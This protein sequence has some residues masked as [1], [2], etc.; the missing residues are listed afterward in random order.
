MRQND[1]WDVRVEFR[2]A[3]DRYFFLLMA[4]IATIVAVATVKP[5]GW[6]ALLVVSLQS[7][8]A[9]LAV[10]TSD[11]KSRTKRLVRV[12]VAVSFSIVLLASVFGTEQIGHYAYSA[13]MLVLVAVV[14]VA[15]ARRLLS[16]E[17]VTLQ[18]VV[19]A[20]CIYLLVGLFF[21]VVQTAYQRETGAFFASGPTESPSDFVYF[22]FVTLATVGY[23]DLVPGAAMAR[24]IAIL[25]ALVGQL[26]L[27]TVVALLVS[28]LSRRDQPPHGGGIGAAIADDLEEREPGD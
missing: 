4:I 11:S 16:H 26:Y 28:N 1:D 12:T 27:V 20:L 22:S 10:S 24:M 19:G 15:I 18:T 17:R 7:F 8:T 21:V 6:G 13:L 9:L 5:E 2:H 23:G 3:L 14:P 25:E